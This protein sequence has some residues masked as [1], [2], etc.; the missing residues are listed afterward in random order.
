[1]DN[2]VLTA[3]VKSGCFRD[4]IKEFHRLN[5][6]GKVFPFTC[7]TPSCNNKRLSK[8]EVRVVDKKIRE[9]LP[10]GA[11]FGWCSDCET[12]YYML[13]TGVVFEQKPQL[14]SDSY[15]SSLKVERPKREYDV[16]L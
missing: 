2:E 10:Q 4:K 6:E 9:D 7:N 11:K 3:K 5:S 14:N 16:E 1:M 8:L 12:F 15:I 13:P